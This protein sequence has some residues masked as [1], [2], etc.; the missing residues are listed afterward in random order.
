[1]S[2]ALFPGLQDMDMGSTASVT[3]PATSGSSACSV[4]QVDL[5]DLKRKVTDKQTQIDQCSPDMARQRRQTDLQST[6][7]TFWAQKQRDFALETKEFEKYMTI[8]GNGVRSLTPMTNYKD[9]LEKDL[10]T[11]QHEIKQYEQ[12][13]R[14]GR[15]RFLD[16]HPQEVVSSMFGIHT[17]DDK[18]ML[19]FWISYL[20]LIVILTF[21]LVSTYS[22]T[23]GL[24]TT[25]KRIAFDL[26]LIGTCYGIAYFF[27]SKFA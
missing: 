12:G 20:L 4:Y 25:G 10:N 19:T 15:R 11:Q 22:E 3:I 21:V 16:N 14:A 5:N 6:F 23:L 24:D 27:I 1:M 13:I 9:E 17:T 7:D 2:G 8:L 18:I 26:F